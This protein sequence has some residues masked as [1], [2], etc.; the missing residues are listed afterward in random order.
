MPGGRAQ[1]PLVIGLTGP[2]G[3]GVS[4]TSQV[5]A[6]KGFHRVS[7]SDAIRKEYRRRNSL[8]DSQ[9]MPRAPDIRN[10]LQDLGNELR[11][12]E[13]PSYWAE[14]TLEDVPEDQDL[15]PG[16]KSAFPG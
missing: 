3:S 14:K 6:R 12:S 11:L 5:L 4:T 7:I 8:P 15:G 2:L 13:S 1:S 9:A 16:S 10:A